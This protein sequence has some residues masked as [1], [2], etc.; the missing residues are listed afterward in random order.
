MVLDGTWLVHLPKLAWWIACEANLGFLIWHLYQPDTA[1]NSPGCFSPSWQQS[2]SS[3]I[4]VRGA[5]C[6]ADAAS[7]C[8]PAQER[9]FRPPLKRHKTYLPGRADRVGRLDH[10]LSWSRNEEPP[11]AAVYGFQARPIKLQSGV[12]CTAKPDHA[13]HMPSICSIHAF[14]NIHITPQAVYRTQA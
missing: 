6:T 14:D 8:C 4:A 11:E 5:A 3:L 1:A 10:V 7:A 13:S 12:E 2:S 9:V